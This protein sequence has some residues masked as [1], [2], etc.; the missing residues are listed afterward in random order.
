MI[1]VVN[2]DK[3]FFSSPKRPDFLWSQPSLL[4]NSYWAFAPGVKRP[5]FEV[6]HPRLSN[7]EVKSKW[8]YTSTSFVCLHDL[9][10]D[11]VTL[12]LSLIW[13]SVISGFLRDVN[14]IC[15]F[16]EDGTDMLSRNVGMELTLYAAQTPREAQIIMLIL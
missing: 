9:E 1:T 10:R 11:N 8:S 12:L 15:A 3:R 16:L 13:I 6:N 5:G 4:L 2:R 14:E 7:A